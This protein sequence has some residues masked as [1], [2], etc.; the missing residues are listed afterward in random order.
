[1][2]IATEN[3]V[4]VVVN[5][6]ENEKEKQADDR[7]SVNENLNVVNEKGSVRGTVATKE[8]TLRIVQDIEFIYPSEEKGIKNE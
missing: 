6:T 4:V 7:L 8:A 5:V 1:M 3:V 2:T